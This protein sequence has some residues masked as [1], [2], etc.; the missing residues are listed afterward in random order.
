MVFR[1]W[2]STL[3]V[4]ALAVTGLGCATTTSA[5]FHMYASPMLEDELSPP[6]ARGLPGGDASAPG[7]L[8]TQVYV[9]RSHS[10]PTSTAAPRRS[11][12]AVGRAPM[13]TITPAARPALA[14]YRPTAA[15]TGA[16][17]TPHQSASE[18]TPPTPAP[19][20]E[21]SLAA[22]YVHA[23]FALNGVA[24]SE[25]AAA[26]V[27]ELYRACR[28]EGKVY[29]SSRPA[30]GDMVFFHNT[31][32]A[33]EDQR[34]NDWYTLV[35]IVE[36]HNAAGTTSV[37]AYLDEGVRRVQLNLEQ[38][39]SKEV[40]GEAANSMLRPPQAE[41]P[42]FTQHLAGQLF[43]GFCNALG[44]RDE[45]MVVDNWQPGMTLEP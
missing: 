8:P 22:A 34:N 40:E 15:S 26:S 1:S 35:G 13:D 27:P 32:D 7:V 36:A 4:F 37:L 29:H 42:P 45:L 41:D 19:T 10:S 43:A 33:N 21:G 23:V 5:P 6:I 24:F 17:T 18:V 11:R 31:Y 12:P 39:D 9:Y 2:Q 28:A 20:G 16:A 25:A 44:E 14:S 3:G 38:V 30:V